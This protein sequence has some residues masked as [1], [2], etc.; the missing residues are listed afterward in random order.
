MLTRLT[1]WPTGGL[2]AFCLLAGGALAQDYPARPVTIVVPYPGGSAPDLVARLVAEKLSPAL[3]QPVRV[4]VRPGSN[5]NIGA[6]AVA[7]SA[8]DGYTL[9][10]AENALLAINPYIYRPLPFNAERDLIPVAPL[11]ESMLFLA[12]N[13]AL[14]V[15]NLLEF[16]DYARRASPPL[17]YAS[18]GVGSQLHISMERLRRAAGLE[19]LHVPYRGSP[20]A[21]AAAIAGDVAVVLAGNHALGFLQAGRLKALA[22]SSAA[23][24]K[25]FPDVPS[26]G[27]YYPGL[28][29]T[30]WQGLFAPATTPASV[31]ERLEYEVGRIL[32]LPELS[33]RLAGAFDLRPLALTRIQFADMLRRE[34]EQHRM[35]WEQL[36]I[37]VE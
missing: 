12:V 13:A 23:R 22:I 32:A 34:R 36:G 16:V 35:Q 27:E 11:G 9:L 10:L 20:Q 30:L 18:A 31:L 2:L 29:M 5:G 28:E 33:R 3:G 4:E 24:S 21:V 1:L 8:P 6:A 17:A 26:V 15:V 7:Q 14:P 19:L 25:T 37:T